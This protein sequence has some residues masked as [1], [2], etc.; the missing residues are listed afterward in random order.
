MEVS[1]L[2]SKI[3][4]AFTGSAEALEEVLQLVEDHQS[5]FPFNEYEHLICTLMQK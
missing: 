3:I 4:N 2:K 1:E 5:I